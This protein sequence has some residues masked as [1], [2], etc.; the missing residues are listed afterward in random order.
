MIGEKVPR[1]QLEKLLVEEKEKSEFLKELNKELKALKPGE[2][3]VYETKEGTESLLGLALRLT[4][5]KHLE[6]IVRPGKVYAC[7]ER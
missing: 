6:L 4:P 3:L 2:C 7:K 5:V 1:E